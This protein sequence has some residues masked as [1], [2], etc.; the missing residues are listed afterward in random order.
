MRT[1]ALFLTVLL[2]GCA[3]PPGLGFARDAV[4]PDP[5]YKEYRE[6]LAG[7]H[8]NV[9]EIPVLEG[10]LQLDLSATL[11]A[12]SNGLSLVET[13]PA[14]LRVALIGPD[15]ATIA[16]MELDPQR[17][18]GNMTVPEPVPGAYLLRVDGFGASQP[19]EGEAYGAGYRLVAEVLY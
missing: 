18:Q 1:L 11:E 17:T 10:A 5:Y 15:G 16:I 13:S 12:R 19:V 2:A 6:L 14:R 8:H 9:Y 3:S 7:E 4:E